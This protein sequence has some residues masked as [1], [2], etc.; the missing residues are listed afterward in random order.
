MSLSSF[1][2]R[3]ALAIA[4]NRSLDRAAMKALLK[5]SELLGLALGHRLTELRDSGDPLQISFSESQT[6]ILFA[7]CYKEAA[8]ILA[9]RWDKLPDKNRPQYT[10]QQRYRI[11]RLKRLFVWNAQ[12]TA[13]LFRLSQDTIERWEREVNAL[14]EKP[15]SSLVRTAPP[16]R[17][18]ADV[19]R[20]LVHTMRLTGFG[21]YKNIS[22]T[23]AR[24]GWRISKT[25][26]AR[27]LR[28]KPP[29]GEPREP[30]EANETKPPPAP[31]K[32]PLRARY[33][34]H[35]FLADLTDIPSLFGI[36]RFKLDLV[37]D[38]F[39]RMPLA[40]RVF[41]QEPTGS[42]IA[43]LLQ[44]AVSRFA[45]C[46]HF[47]SDQ[48]SQFT[49]EL[50]R[51]TCKSLVIRQR[52]GAIG[53][54]ASI[55]ILERFWRTLKTLALLKVFPPLVHNELERRLELS[56]HYYAFLRPHQGLGGATPAE[57]Y[58]GQKPAHLSALPLLEAGPQRDP[59]KHPSA[60]STWTEKRG[61]PIS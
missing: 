15:T 51:H 47:V 60:S 43:T 25:T 37:F 9:S 24:T 1:A 18:F 59:L 39:S 46:R 22:Q 30:A 17:R 5:A 3:V 13:R 58:Y 38:V 53:K 26:V 45:L 34:N 12:E 20:Q 44:D 29:L 52:F 11:L 28:E 50:F 19:V 8:D 40:A 56:L 36:F 6:S 14:D 57:L 16:L 31:H 55:A 49:S 7:T 10:P 2:E 48:G 41:F 27:I 42:E 33:P 54:V 21:G 32:G 61:S 35:I 4:K 23:L